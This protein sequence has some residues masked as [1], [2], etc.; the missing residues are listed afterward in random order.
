MPSQS[1][2]RRA[3]G[4]PDNA[5]TG[6]AKTVA[7]HRSLLAGMTKRLGHY[8]NCLPARQEGLEGKFVMYF[9][10]PKGAGHGQDTRCTQH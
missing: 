8:D 5:F 7:R 1:D 2:F 6:K 3:R 9:V 4:A 10:S